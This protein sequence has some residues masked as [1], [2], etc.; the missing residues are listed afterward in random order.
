MLSLAY[1]VVVHAENGMTLA[2]QGSGNEK[3]H[4]PSHYASRCGRSC[5]DMVQILY[6]AGKKNEVFTNYTEMF[7]YVKRYS[8]QWLVS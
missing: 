6:A 7:L 5:C 4:P 8:L 2:P 1:P 3:K